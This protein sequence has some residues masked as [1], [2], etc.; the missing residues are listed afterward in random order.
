MN[1]PSKW[2]H[3]GEK[4]KKPLHY[5]DCG[6]DD[7]Y[8]LSG[9]EVE[10]TPYGEGISVRNVDQL[11][12]AIG[13]HL[14]RQKKTLSGKELRFLRKELDLTQSNL[15]KMLG[16]SAQ[17]VARW[18]KEESDISG[19]ADILVRALFIQHVC[20]KL[21][22]QELIKSLEELDTPISEEKSFFENTDG[23]WKLKVAA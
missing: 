9:Y 4:D 20:G 18:E 12:K 10:H 7:V 23:D 13:Y 1:R 19:A 11:R 6:L 22:L 3:A 21:D 2:R 5:T 15:G 14:T 8:L 17:Q 16:L